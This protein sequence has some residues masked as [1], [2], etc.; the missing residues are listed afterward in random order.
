M[1]Q[2]LPL[3]LALPLSLSAGE[4]SSEITFE[5]RLFTEEALSDAQSDSNLSVAF[6]TEFYHDWD[7]G[8]QS[9][10]FTPFIR[11]DQQDEARS[12][13]DIRELMWLYAAE[14]W[15]LQAGLGRVFW[16]ITEAIHL[17]DIINQ[18]DLVE[19]PDGEQK[20]GQPMVKLSLEREIGIFDLFILPGFRE[21][22]FPGEDG[23]LRSHPHV[24]GDQANYESSD[25]ARHIDL[26]L[27][28]SHSLGDWE[29]GLSHF[30]GTSRDPRFQLAT[31]NSQPVLTP[32]YDLIHQTGLDIQATLGDLLWKLEAISRRGQGEQYIA[33]AGGFEGTLVGIFD[34]NADLG[35]IAEYLYDDRNKEA[36]TPFQNDLFLALRWTAN[37]E[38]SLEILGGVIL[39]LDSDARVLN[40]EASRRLGEDWKA[41]L[42]GRFWQQIP[43]SDAGYGMSRDDYIEVTLRRYF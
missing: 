5:G 38:Q 31:D 35:L 28:W 26:A 3:L 21:R 18:T 13:T 16:G 29:V 33:A 8:K 37:D 40:L 34:S 30:Y 10:T 9:I 25:E 22:T 39:D 2:L 36:P 14:E 20:L 32:Y 12:H 27:R 42:Q 41:S 15:E 7:D 4:W 11:W 6:E 17:V 23:R 43:I 19:S 1:R 24:D